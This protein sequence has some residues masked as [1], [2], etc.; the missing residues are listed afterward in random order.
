MKKYTLKNLMD[1]H[2]SHQNIAP[3]TQ[4][5]V[6]KIVVNSDDTEILEEEA[7]YV[8]FKYLGT[9][10]ALY[11]DEKFNRM[12]VIS[13]ITTYSTLA[14]KIKDSLMSANFHSALD[15]RY[16]VAEDTLYA[17]FFHPLDSLTQEDFLSA[18]KQ[19]HNLAQSFGKTYSSAQ[20]EFTKKK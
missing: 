17:L 3:M 5:R 10:M 18:L 2:A 7:G 19:L 8:L 6:Q 11:P 1:E 9:K 16:G 4:K 20:L 13:P 15:C 12:R 14:P